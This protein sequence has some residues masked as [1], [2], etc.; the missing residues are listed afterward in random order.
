MAATALML[1]SCTSDIVS[2]MV[3]D[4]SERVTFTATTESEDDDATRGLISE[5]TGAAFQDT[6]AGKPLMLSATVTG[7]ASASAAKATVGGD[8]VAASASTRGLRF[9]DGESDELTTFFVSAIKTDNDVNTEQFALSTPDFFYN[10]PATKNAGGIF[11]ITQDY[12]WPASSD[13]LWFYAYTFAPYSDNNSNVVVSSQETGGAQKVTF[14][15]DTDVASQVD[16]MTANTETQ[17]FNSASGTTKKA[18]VPLAFRHELT[19]IRFVIGEQWLAGSIKSVAIRNVHGVGTLTIGGGWAWTNASGTEVTATDDFELTLNRASV[20]GTEGDEFM[21]AECGTGDFSSHYFLMI[22]QSFDDN[23]DAVVEIVYQDAASEYTVTAPL[24]GQSAWVRNTTVT[25]AISSHT[26]TTL[27]IGSISWPDESAEGAWNGPK[28]AFA[29]GDEIGLYVVNPDGVTIPENR[30]NIRCTYDGNSSWTIHHPEND[31]VYKLPGYQYFFYYPYTPT[32]DTKYPVAGQNTT[33]TTASDFF[34]TL[35]SGWEPAVVQSNQ[36]IFLKQDL[37]IGKGADVSGLPANIN[38]QM[39]HQMDLAVV[40][41]KTKEITDIIIYALSNDDSYKWNHQQTVTNVTASPEFDTNIP[42]YT[43]SK[44]YFVFKPGTTAT[45]LKGLRSGSA[46]WSHDFSSSDRGLAY[47]YDAYT[48]RENSTAN[49]TYA[50]ALGDV[51]YSNGAVSHSRITGNSCYGT[52]IGVVVC[53]GSGAMVENKHAL[54]MAGKEAAN[55][56]WSKD[57][58]DISAITNTSGENAATSYGGLSN[59]FWF[60]NQSS[61]STNYPAAY[62]ARHYNVT[63]PSFTTGWFLAS[64]GQWAQSIQQ[65]GTPLTGWNNWVKPEPDLTA[66]NTINTYLAKLGSGNYTALSKYLYTTSSEFSD[67]RELHIIFWDNYGTVL[68]EDIMDIQNDLPSE[69]N[70]QFSYKVRPFLAF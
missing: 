64:S 16:L 45:R 22:P 21:D 54:V 59:T 68:D 2:S 60:N 13:K 12:Y 1:S 9:G 70:K 56:K 57:L 46:D 18:A 52:P 28:T 47:E 33:N 67:E 63:Y 29:A 66:F 30:R 6:Q 40:T 32:P 19:A 14:T 49:Q 27:K 69:D 48:A 4:D 23:D 62:N 58:T 10:L 8:F 42:Y 3:H 11:E 31:P 55:G 35:V 7:R 41:L 43:D 61:A 44:Y 36:D 20:A 17:G 15:V 38:V 50:L 25:Y 5:T 39:A 53:I 51:Y 24:K 34:G 26:L 65:C 37:Q